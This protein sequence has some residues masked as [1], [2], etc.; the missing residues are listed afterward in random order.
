MM[1][2]NQSILKSYLLI[3]KTLHGDPGENLSVIIKGD[4]GQTERISV[5]KSQV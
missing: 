2:E 3:L 1:N 5:G 4:K